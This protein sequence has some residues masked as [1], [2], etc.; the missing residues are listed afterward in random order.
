M[1][2]MKFQHPPYSTAQGKSNKVILQSPYD[3]PVH[4]AWPLRQKV[5]SF[6]INSEQTCI[7]N[8]MLSLKSPLK[9]QTPAQFYM[10][11]QSP[12][13]LQIMIHL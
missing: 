1:I 12:A 7:P 8:A 13:L 10:T 6:K 4:K 5:L 9:S 2:I 11:Q 3:I